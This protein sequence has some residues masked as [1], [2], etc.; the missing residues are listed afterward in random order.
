MVDLARAQVPVSASAIRADVHGQRAWLAPGVYGHF[1]QRIALMGAESTGKSTLA[2]YMAERCGTRFVPEIGRE[3]W[4]ARQGRLAPEDYVAIAKRHRA[5]EDAALEHCQRYLFVD[6]NAL[7]TLL[8]GFC[9][10]HLLEAP[11]ELLGYARDCARRY[12]A[13]FLCGDEIPFDQDGWRDDAGWRSRIQGMVRYDLQ[14]RGIPYMELNGTLE[15]RAGQLLAKLEE[16]RGR[17][18]SGWSE[19]AG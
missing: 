6:T 17:S 13:H 14:V 2:A 5:A 12:A 10:G 15:Q 3:V 11:P 18:D 19:R 8:L 16:E 4:E 7:T 9:Y 1:V